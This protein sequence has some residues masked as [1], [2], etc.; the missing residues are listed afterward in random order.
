MVPADLDDLEV[1]AI[2]DMEDFD[3][4]GFSSIFYFG[5]FLPFCMIC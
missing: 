3:L 2:I 4:K 1:P 5:M